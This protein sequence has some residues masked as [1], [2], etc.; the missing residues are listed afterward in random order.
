MGE[1]VAL[2]PRCYTL[3][4]LADLVGGEVHG[5]DNV[6]I[7][8]VA[9]IREAKGGDITFLA[10]P[11]Y[12]EFL[13][14]TSASAVIAPSGCESAVPAIQIDNPYYAYLKVLRLFAEEKS[15]TYVAGVHETAVVE[16]EVE[17]GANV[18]IG[19]YVHIER[20][21]RIGTN[22]TILS[23]S[24]VG[25]GSVVGDDSFVYPNVTVREG[26]E[27]GKR[28]IL[29][30]GVVIGADGF[31]FAKDNGVHHKIPQIGRVVIEDDVEVGANSTIDRATTGETRI[32]RGTKID[33]LVQIAHNVI[34][35]KHCVIAAQV[36][37]SGSTTIG[38]DV[39][40]A[41]QA[42]L[43]GHIN[44][45]DGAVV[46]GQAGVFGS[47]DPGA[48]VSG[49]PARDHLRATRVLAAV[50]KLPELLKQVRELEAKL[51]ALENGDSIGSPTEND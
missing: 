7:V 47:V 27:V 22:V 40:L 10:N 26:C 16:S 36:G 49:Y 29:H 20:G 35:G 8:G 15:L 19:P 39:T 44:V 34:I 38:D 51:A 46:G 11:K 2:R 28:V 9:G 6:E 30:S 37:I 43:Q 12:L 1:S 48:V 3:K 5:D 23:G 42:G 32:G 18:C 33:N 25:R 21:A 45:G 41:G 24:F 13:E 4:E 14:T 50:Q 17:L 31:G